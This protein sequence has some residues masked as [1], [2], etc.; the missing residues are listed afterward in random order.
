MMILCDFY[1]EEYEIFCNL[2]VKWCEE[3]IVLNVE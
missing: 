2:V 1:E 3:Y